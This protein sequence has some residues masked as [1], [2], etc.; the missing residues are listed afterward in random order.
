MRAF[1]L[2]ML[3]LACVPS[4]APPPPSA[5]E[6]PTRVAGLPVVKLPE[7]QLPERLARGV[8]AVRST[9]ALTLPDPGDASGEAREAFLRDAYAPALQAL[10]LSARRAERTL[11]PLREGS[12]V[13]KRAYVLLVILLERHVIE[14]V[15]ALPPAPEAQGDAAGAHRRR[16]EGQVRSRARMALSFAEACSSELDGFGP[17]YGPW[18]PVCARVADECRALATPSA[19]AVLGRVRRAPV[20]LPAECEGPMRYEDPQA[21][22]RDASAPPALRVELDRSIPAAARESLREVLRRTLPDHG[23][24]PAVPAAALAEAERLHAESR[25]APGSPRCRE[26]PPRLAILGRTHPNLV[27]AR[28]EAWCAEGA[29]HLSVFAW[30]AGDE[31]SEGLPPSL[32]APVDDP[33]DEGQLV[34]AALRLVP[35]PPGGM[36]GLGLR[37]S[38]PSVVRTL[39]RTRSDPFLRVA[40][41]LWDGR[42]ELADC[43]PPGTSVSVDASW[44]VAPDGSTVEPSVVPRTMPA[45]VDTD[46][47]V[48]C[49]ERV[50]AAKGWRCPR[51]GEAER[52]EALLCVGRPADAD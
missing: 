10:T 48:A 2:A 18:R 13:E 7:A 52:V 4:A 49:I 16:L 30:R 23:F 29:C 46:D 37:G 3:A 36:G 26:A 51:S 20:R 40:P 47:V 41:A 38:G 19:P 1:L 8:S 45:D 35:E 5:A 22:P 31:E 39:E 21:L 50:I 34:A 17:L 25:W 28:A 42:A 9:L 6:N 15:L 27:L 43:V 11:A 32:Y 44:E 12:S 14:Q 24:P 33:R